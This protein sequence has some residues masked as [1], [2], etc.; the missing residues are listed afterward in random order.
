MS[1]IADDLGAWVVALLADAG[2]KKLATLILGTEQERALRQAASAA[3]WRT[4]GELRPEGGAQTE[5]LAMVV[6]QVFGEPLPL[7]DISSG[8]QTTLLQTLR[9]G[10]YGQLAIMGDAD[11]TGTEQSSAEALGVSL[12]ALSEK[13]TSHLLREIIVRGSRGGP[14]EPLA[15]Q[16]NH[17]VTHLQG[18]RLERNFEQLADEVREALARLDLGQT[19]SPPVL[20]VT[21]TLP[22][23]TAAFTGREEELD[24][25]IAAAADAGQV[26]SVCTI[27]GM[28]GVGKTALAVHAAHLLKHRFPDRQ[29]FIDLHAHTP[30]QDPLIP[31]TALA[32]MLTA[33]GVDPRYLPEDLEGRAA[34]WRNRMA[35]QRVLLVLDNASNSGQVAPLLPGADGCFVLVTSRRHLGDVP[36]TA[37]G[38]QLKT[39]PPDKAREMF[40]RLAL[41]AA[42]DTPGVVAELVRLAGFLPLGISLLA[43]V[44]AKHPSWTLADLTD[45]TKKSL[46]TLAAERDSVAAAFDVSYRYLSL[47]QQQF[48]SRLGLHLG[49]TI[50]AY[51][52]AALADIRMRDAA[53]HLEALYGEGLLTE[54]GYRRYG[55]HDLIRRYA[56]GRAAEHERAVDRLL[57]YY[58]QTAAIAETRIARQGL[59][60]SIPAQL[61]A[62]APELPDRDRA[63]TWVRIER[64]NLFACL[65]HATESGEHARVVALTAAMAS[66]LRHDGP[67]AD[68]IARHATAMRAAQRV[69]DRSGQA[70]ALKNLGLVRQLTGDY[71][72]AVQALEEALQIARDIGDQSGQANALDGLG[73]VRRRIG[74]YAGAVQALEE[75]LQ[76]ARDIGDRLGQANALTSLGYVRQLTGDYAGAVQALEEALQIARDIGD[77]LGQANALRNLG[78][79]RQLT[80]NYPGAVQALEE[81]LQ[82][83]RDIGDRLSQA[84]VLRNLGA[85]RQHVGDFPGAVQALEQALQ[86]NRVIGSRRGEAN[87]LLY[88]GTVRQH[89]GDLP[90]A[91]EDLEQALGVFRDLGDRGGEVT[92]LN[93]TGTLQRTRGRLGLAE[94]CH[95]QALNL[96]RQNENSWDEAHALAGLAR[97]A[98]ADGRAAEAKSGLLQA[99]E[100]FQRIGA[101]EARGISAEL[102]TLT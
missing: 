71:P 102:A 81:A 39:L 48:L 56:R 73:I 20:G 36:G 41:R 37:V 79:V 18:Q 86:I 40:V 45:E 50:D 34:L 66:L 35:G 11:L 53:G 88:L 61:P 70:N 43:R 62:A 29:V 12:A 91:A 47:G 90:G 75:A 96:A 27:D 9:A 68:A 93:M 94:T 10:I 46:L 92:V 77:R 63:L 17:D 78:L 16:L 52:A 6:S 54:P 2:R 1:F 58:Q 42:T 14:L 80:G 23:D 89:I 25:I 84:N 8:E 83:A 55:M 15:A 4:A 72:G 26:T 7:P 57:D 64:D 98:L 69:G 21:Y 24:S 19:V 44:Y 67:W 51:A 95:Q 32:G 13:L 100:I 82:I 76:I 59:T 85:I 31:E 74:D 65:N 97:C 49:N 3:V 101:D 99:L 60:G 33:V 5:E 22:R 38:L 28:P 87:A 30:N